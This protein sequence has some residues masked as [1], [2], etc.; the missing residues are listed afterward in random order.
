[1]DATRKH[2]MMIPFEA[3]AS[4]SVVKRIQETTIKYT[5]DRKAVDLTARTVSVNRNPTLCQ[6][7]VIAVSQKSAST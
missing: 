5:A 1:M 4:A 6:I 7:M 2:Y 3:D